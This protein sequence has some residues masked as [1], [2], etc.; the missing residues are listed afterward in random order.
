MTS[1]YYE[2]SGTGPDLILLHGWGLHGGAFRGL[3]D[4]LSD[5]FC[6]TA[7]DLPGFGRSPAGSETMSLDDTADSIANLIAKP[8]VWLGWSLGGLV[9][10][11]LATRHRDLVRGMVLVAATPRF[12]Q[13][14]DWSSGMAPETFSSFAD[15]LSDD[16]RATLK[17]FVS[18]QTDSGSA[19]RELIRQLREEVFKHGEP[20]VESL[21]AGLELLRN[22]DLR[23]SLSE[24]KVPALLIHGD[25]DRLTPAAA[26]EY[27]AQTLPGAEMLLVK[28]AGH[29]PFVSHTDSV[30][31]SIRGFI[32]GL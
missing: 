31:A 21:A 3:M 1:L 14:S 6:V 11:R 28:G 2:Q 26:S 29:A 18:L 8:A 19:S 15:G 25:Q 22:T 4:A 23:Q 16:Y 13:A 32:H 17:R 30:A 12:V 9:A 20:N 5:E 10:M 24:T 7:I 27:L